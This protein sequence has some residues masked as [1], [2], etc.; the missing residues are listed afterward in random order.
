MHNAENSLSFAPS[1]PAADV[2]A[3]AYF[4]RWLDADPA[5]RA[6]LLAELAATNPA[7]HVCLLELIEADRTAAALHF[8]DSGA[9]S[10]VGAEPDETTLRDLAGSQ[11]G[12][13]RLQRLIGVGGAGQ[14]WFAR[15]CDGQHDGSAAIKLLRVTDLDAYAQRRFAREGRVLAGLEHPHIARLIDVGESAHGQRYI[16]LEYIDGER[17]DHWCD[18]HQTAIDARLRLFLQVCDAVSYAHAHLVVHRDL[19][20]SNILVQE[21][22][23]VKLLDFGV[24]KLLTG[25]TPTDGAELTELTSAAG[26][27]FTPEYASPEQFEGRPV[28]V[29]SDVYSLGVVLYLLLTGRRPYGEDASTPVQ[30]ARVIAEHEPLRLSAATS[31]RTG[32]TETIAA[33]RATTPEQLRRVLRGDLDTIVGKALKKA[34]ADRYASVQMLADDLRRYL[35]HRPIVARADSARYR[36]RKFMRRH[37]VGVGVS[38]LFALAVLA[39]V[40]STVWQAHEARRHAE[41]AERSKAFLA[42][43]IQDTNPFSI[44]RGQSNTASALDNAL[45]RVDSDFADSPETQTE[46][47]QDIE[48]VLLKIGEYAKARDVGRINLAALRAHG[49]TGAVLGVALSDFGIANSNL[50][51][52]AAARAAFAEAEPLMRDAGPAYRRERISLMTGMAKLDNQE[53]DHASAHRL[54]EAVLLERQALEGEASPDVAM[55]LMNLAADAYDVEHYTE[56]ELL[57][58]RSHDMLIKL[59]G[60][61]HARR[62]YVD[63]MLGVAQI[64]VGRE[65]LAVKTL[66]HVVE[67]ARSTLGPDAV[68]LGIALGNLG[69]AYY[70]VGDGTS[71]LVT[72]REASQVLSKVKYPGRGRSMLKLGLVE[73][74]MSDPGAEKDL[75]DAREILASTSGGR[76]GY[77]EWARAA[78]GAALVRGGDAA[79]GEAEARSARAD[80]L[81]GKAATSVH[82]GDVDVLL[83][84]ILD[85]RGGTSEAATLRDEAKLAYTR[86]LGANHPKVQALR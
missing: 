38:V 45:R 57:A 79:G 48:S 54:H 40:A 1:A 26:A 43:L 32:N 12:A 47:R 66:R 42:S 71:A 18:R 72:L 25:D 4:E 78:H 35:D 8:L 61:E 14:V 63:N 74:G 70:R 3:M 46:L 60:P 17:I 27:A 23:E 55:D 80:L 52:A 31:E 5:Q 6:Q 69:H 19:K 36:L 56:A 86:V 21:D 15:R 9:L 10:N 16:V 20:P 59:L 58:Q 73:L 33:R 85:T 24:A 22:G 37:R 81:A 64:E 83:A 84:G 53:G 39:G 41:R 75:L 7:A 82:L 68:M 49:A 50:G 29:T 34:P 11:F 30:L 65:T 77:L 76:D 51:D 13:W 28:S 2:A 67:M 62:I 44:N